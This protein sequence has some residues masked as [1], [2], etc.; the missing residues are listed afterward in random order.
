MSRVIIV[1]N[2]Q[3]EFQKEKW[4]LTIINH[5]K[6]VEIIGSRSLVKM[7]ENTDQ[8][9]DNNFSYNSN[10]SILF[11]TNE[12]LRGIENIYKH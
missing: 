9:K 1:V 12:Y 2:G 8:S 7:K 4:I 6:M 3:V 5:I 10:S 11:K